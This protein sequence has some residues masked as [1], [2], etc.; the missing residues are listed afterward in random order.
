MM[1]RALLIC[2]ALA[3][4]A[5]AQAWSVPAVV[6]PS[7]ASSFQ[8]TGTT[9]P[10]S[11]VD[12][13]NDF[14]V[15]V[16]DFG[17]DN[18]GAIDSTTAINAAIVKF[19]SIMAAGGSGA[20][21]T[22]KIPPGKYLV[23]APVS[24]EGIN[25]R[26]A[27]VD[28]TG[29]TLL[30]QTGGLPVLSLYGSRWLNLQG[31]HVFGSSSSPPSIGIQYGRSST[32]SCAEGRWNNIVV[33]GTFSFTGVYLFGCESQSY[34]SMM[35]RNLSTAP[36]TFALVLDGINHWGVAPLTLAA[37]AADT[38]V[39]MHEVWMP[40]INLATFG[41][42]A[43]SAPIWVSHVEGLRIEGYMAGSSQQNVIL[44]AGTAAGVNDS[45][46]DVSWDIHSENTGN[47]ALQYEFFIT[48]ANVNPQ[49]TQFD[50]RTSFEN[51][52]VVVYKLDS[53]IV[54]VTM[55]DSEVIRAPFTGSGG[56]V[57]FD[58]PNLWTVSGRYHLPP[59]SLSWNLPGFVGSGTVG[60]SVLLSGSG[61][62]LTGIVP[63]LPSNIAASTISNVGG[64]T[65]IALT[66]NTKYDIDSWCFHTGTPCSASL[67]HQFP[68]VAISAPPP[69]G[70]Q[71]TAVVGSV[72]GGGNTVLDAF[73]S[74]GFIA[75]AT[76]GTGYT[77]NNT[78]TMVGGTCSVT[79]TWVLH[80]V[81][82]GVVTQ[83]TTNT[84][85]TCSILPP[86]PISV[87]GGSGTG[88]TIGGLTWVPA[89]ITMTATGA[90][91][92]GVPAVSI[93]AT[94]FNASPSQTLTATTNATITVAA[95]NGNI[96][97][98]SSGTTVGLAGSTISAIA[99]LL[100]GKTKFTTTGCSISA[101]AGSGTAGTYT[102]GVTGSCAAVITI[103]G[104][105]GMTAPTGWACSAT[106]RTTPADIQ[107]QTASTPT[108]ATITGTTVSGDVIA[109]QCQPY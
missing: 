90:G 107:N 25:T 3:S 27:V 38:P 24:L 21:Y 100:G 85:G 102:S 42:D 68:I 71:A 17:A 34:Q 53:N 1:R 83:L 18:T 65:S 23:T 54:S 91:Y 106:D 103:N 51:A 76:G 87:T 61:S 80:A 101:T 77:V 50:Y 89:S 15:N 26:G 56:M 46:F 94:S 6:A 32:L 13:S 7:G 20:T 47:A 55:T 79:P 75:P 22:L 72:S 31:L 81:S 14:G 40:H 35:V 33:E 97:M 99:P 95:G 29:A 84:V 92:I 62:N 73:G 93:Q 104:A 41:T 9:T 30:G 98:D 96:S 45:I 64:V 4:L 36:S 109:F 59:G 66:G 82:G 49:F 78:V 52:P 10:R 16:L 69:G 48:G 67:A 74:A 63:S 2:S 19:K 8:A 57:V 88:L 86:E 39:G 28:A 37:A 60:S 105:T 43:A 5:S 58:Q 11:P 108:T 70:A 12:R 44:W